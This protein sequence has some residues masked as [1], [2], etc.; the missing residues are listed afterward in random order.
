MQSEFQ[1]AHNQ[2]FFYFI[3]HLGWRLGC[4]VQCTSFSTFNAQNYVSIILTFS[5]NIF[6]VTAAKPYATA[7]ISFF[8]L[9]LRVSCQFFYIST[10]A[11]S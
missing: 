1:G 7:H 8:F 11:S 10:G 4:W 5:V 2:S 6:P 3:L 9:L